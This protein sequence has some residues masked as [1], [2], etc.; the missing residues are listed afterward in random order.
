MYRCIDVYSK[1]SSLKSI[2]YDEFYR[3]DAKN[4][5]IDF[6]KK[7]KKEERERE[8]ERIENYYVSV[9]Y[10]YIIFSFSLVI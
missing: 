8:R 4:E 3:C 2:R 5:T 10:V 9:R 1:E 6:L 7:R